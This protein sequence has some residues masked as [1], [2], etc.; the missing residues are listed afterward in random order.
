[1][2]EHEEGN[3]IEPEKETNPQHEPERENEGEFVGT[4]AFNERLFTRQYNNRGAM[5][6]QLL[7]KSIRKEL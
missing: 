2:M 5:I 1:M 4:K 6:L 7:V 3:G